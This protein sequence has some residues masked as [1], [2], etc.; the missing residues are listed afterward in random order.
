[1]PA[2]ST[3]PV[4]VG[5][6]LEVTREQLV[7]DAGQERG[8]L[9][10]PARAYRQHLAAIE[11]DAVLARVEHR[12]ATQDAILEIEHDLAH[13]LLDGRALEPAQ[14]RR[15]LRHR[16]DRSAPAQPLGFTHAHDPHGAPQLPAHAPKDDFVRDSGTAHA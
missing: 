16:R 5:G 2:V 12:F 9:E 10:V 15:R 7:I 4:V 11:I 6:Q 14:R 13:R 1:M 8:A 3:G